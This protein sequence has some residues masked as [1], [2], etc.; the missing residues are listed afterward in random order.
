MANSPVSVA[1]DSRSTQ[2]LPPDRLFRHSIQPVTLVPRM[3]PMMTP[4]ACRTFIMP[5]L[6]KPTT[7][8]EVAE[9]DWMTAV[10]AVPSSTPFSGVPDSL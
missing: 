4:M 1:V 8:T 2:P 9:E 7:I 10:T 5:E 3:A 6:T